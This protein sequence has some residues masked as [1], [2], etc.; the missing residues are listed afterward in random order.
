MLHPPLLIYLKNLLSRLQIQTSIDNERQLSRDSRESRINDV[1]IPQPQPPPSTPIRTRIVTSS[2]SVV[3]PGAIRS[4]LAKS[5][6][7]A[8]S[9]TVTF[10]QETEDLNFANEYIPNTPSADMTNGKKKSRDRS[11]RS[12]TST[13]P[14]SNLDVKSINKSSC[15]TLRKIYPTTPRNTSPNTPTEMSS[16]E[17]RLPKLASSPIPQGTNPITENHSEITLPKL[18]K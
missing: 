17:L 14:S 5:P 18:I 1:D 11:P 12:W 8:T 4:G 16:E 10:M 13:R 6:V 7:I 15:G 2:S 3:T 9:K